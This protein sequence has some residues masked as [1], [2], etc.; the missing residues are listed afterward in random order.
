MLMP[1]YHNFARFR[2]AHL[3]IRFWYE[4]K[5]FFCA[6]FAVF[7]VVVFNFNSLQLHPQNLSLQY[8]FHIFYIEVS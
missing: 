5:Y 6:V 2:F 8:Q 4:T 1:K 3:Y 7:V